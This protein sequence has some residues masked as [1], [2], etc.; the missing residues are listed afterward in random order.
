MAYKADRFRFYQ[1]VLTNKEGGEI[2]F[3]VPRV[4]GASFT[5]MKVFINIPAST[6]ITPVFTYV[7]DLSKP[8]RL[9]LISMPLYLMMV[10]I[11]YGLK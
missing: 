8:Y 1:P 2:Q 3:R 9:H 6:V 11:V 7:T 4:Q 5:N 10:K